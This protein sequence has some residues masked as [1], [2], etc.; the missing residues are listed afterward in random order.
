MTETLEHLPAFQFPTWIILA[1]A[2]MYA[3]SV[4]ITTLVLIY[5]A[6]YLTLEKHYIVILVVENASC[7][8]ISLAGFANNLLMVNGFYN[9]TSCYWQ[10]FILYYVSLTESVASALIS[11]LR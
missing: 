5:I 7:L 3:I 9:L 1:W 4:A 10:F 6:K 11:I 2:G 8:V